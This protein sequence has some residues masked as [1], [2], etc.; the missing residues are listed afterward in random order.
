MDHVARMEVGGG[1]AEGE[2][3]ETGEARLQGEHGVRAV[4]PA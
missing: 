2:G 4:V 1:A 3:A